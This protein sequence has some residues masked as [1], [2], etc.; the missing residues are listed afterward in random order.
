MNQVKRQ[1]RSL[2]GKWR[3]ACLLLSMALLV[4]ALWIVAPSVQAFLD[5]EDSLAAVRDYEALLVATHALSAER[6]PSNVLMSVEAGSDPAVAARLRLARRTTDA[7]L[8]VV[9]RAATL[10]TAP[11]TLRSLKADLESARARI[12]A[13][14]AMPQAERSLE[15][16]ADAID[17]MFAIVDAIQPSVARAAALLEARN[18][19]LSRSVFTALIATELREQ[20]GRLGS[21]V[22]PSVSRGLALSPEAVDSV[23]QTRGRI[24]QLVQMLGARL[25]IADADL[26]QQMGEV[27]RRFI[28]RGVGLIERLT[29][30]GRRAAHYSIAPAELTGL[31]VPTLLPLEDLRKAAIG[32]MVTDIGHSRDLALLRLVGIVAATL[33][34]LVLL[35]VVMRRLFLS[36]LRPLLTAQAMIVG[37]AEERPLPRAARHADTQELNDLFEAISRLESQL[38]ERRELTQRLRFRAETDPLTGLFNRARFFGLGDERFAEASAAAGDGGKRRIEGDMPESRVGVLYLDLDGFKTVND[39]HGHFAG[40]QLLREIAS[41]LSNVVGPQA[42]LA[43]LGGDEFAI[44]TRGLDA[45]DLQA[46]AR[47][48]LRAFNKPIIIGGL[49][50][51]VGASIGLALMDALREADAASGQDAGSVAE[52]ASFAQLCAQADAA[53][54]EAKRGGRNTYRL[55]GDAMA[56]TDASPQAHRLQALAG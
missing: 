26:R 54:Y 16:M 6:G 44:C 24:D 28:G 43:R 47:R 21:Y 46:F 19:T 9:D 36:V 35:V 34:V 40:D 37:L 56:R 20:A 55:Y 1:A 41:R 15:I 11:G 51:H 3:H 30:E 52:A 50:V 31:Y 45:A 17:R 22:V 39:T 14:A 48:I 13:I 33:L 10:A 2:Y 12:D 27:R 29:R 25:D 23:N 4:M 8:S 53:L 32:N 49:P 38:S 18:P 7:A 5:A 42:L